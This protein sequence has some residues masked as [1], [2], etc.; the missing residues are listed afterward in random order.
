VNKTRVAAGI[1]YDQEGESAPLLGVKGEGEVA[2]QIIKLAERFGVPV[3]E[4]NQTAQ[5][6][7]KLPIDQEIS[8]ELYEAVAIILH[9]IDQADAKETGEPPA[10]DSNLK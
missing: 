1:H 6:L 9:Q 5:L 7:L 3:V 8:P 10:R 4:D 2:E